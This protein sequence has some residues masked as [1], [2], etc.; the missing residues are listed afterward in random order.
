MGYFTSVTS[1]GI[2]VTA[3]WNLQS[4]ETRQFVQQHV[5]GNYKWNIKALVLFDRNPVVIGGY[6][7]QKATK[8]KNVS[9]PW[10]HN[11][12]SRLFERWLTEKLYNIISFSSNINNK[13]VVLLKKLLLHRR[14]SK[15]QILIQPMTRIS[16]SM[17]VYTIAFPGCI[18]RFVCN[19]LWYENW[20]WKWYLLYWLTFKSHSAQTIEFQNLTM[21][22][23]LDY[24]ASWIYLYLLLWK[25][26]N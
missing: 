21:V 15:W 8:A 24:R 7:L 22:C 9:M 26:L 10:F 5:K 2:T 13:N 23:T 25:A 1:Y 20:Q 19:R 3:S 11:T 18:V 16:V 6:P 14:L 17:I 12:W 4:T